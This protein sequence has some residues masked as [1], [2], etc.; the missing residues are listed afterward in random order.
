MSEKLQKILAQCGLGSRRK[1]EGWI[2]AGRVKVN[3]Q[4]AQ[5]GDRVEATASEIRVDGSVVPASMPGRRASEEKG[6]PLPT[7]LLYHKP[8]GEICTQAD[9]Q[10]RTSVFDQLPK[11]PIGRWVMVGRLD[12]NTSGLLLFTNDGAL[13]NHLMHPSNG[14]ARVYAVRLFGALSAGSLAKLRTGVRLADGRAAFD[15]IEATSGN[16]TNRWYQVSLK[17]GRNRIVRRLFE[18]QGIKINRLIRLGFGSISLPKTLAPGKW[19][20]L[21]TRQVLDLQR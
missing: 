3:G 15:S 6:P 2:A 16:G 20:F 19:M 5:L 4:V 1:M 11:P 8:V 21:P 7:V 12:F 9:P 13:A 14:H 17:L 10:G 18:S